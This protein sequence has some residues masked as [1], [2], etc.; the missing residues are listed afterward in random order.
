[1]VH[2]KQG[3]Y[4]K[5]NGNQNK[6]ELYPYMS[7]NISMITLDENN[8]KTILKTHLNMTGNKRMKKIQTNARVIKP[9]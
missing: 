4:F 8:I 3:K 2:K 7:P 9:V 1:M 6:N 5:K